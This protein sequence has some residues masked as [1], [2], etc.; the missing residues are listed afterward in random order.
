MVPFEGRERWCPAPSGGQTGV[1][2]EPGDAAPSDKRITHTGFESSDSGKVTF[3]C[4]KSP[5]KRLC[6]R[7]GGQNT[8]P[9]NMTLFVLCYGTFYVGS[10]RLDQLNT[11]KVAAE[12]RQESDRKCKKVRNHAFCFFT[13]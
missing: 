4:A 6:K 2:W 12:L 11:L 7:F 5:V 13:L 3:S 1:V 8:L 9:F 10:T